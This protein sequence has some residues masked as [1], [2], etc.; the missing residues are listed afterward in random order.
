MNLS[1]FD[2]NCK[3]SKKIFEDKRLLKYII[4]V[5]DE[6]L[7]KNF[8]TKFEL[9]LTSATPV[10][11][12]K[13]TLCSPNTCGVNA[14]CLEEN[15]KASCKCL[16]GFPVGDPYVSCRQDCVTNSHCSLDKACIN[17][18]CVDPC[19]GACGTDA[20][21]RVPNHVPICTCPQGYTGSPY[22]RCYPITGM[23]YNTLIFYLIN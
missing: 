6:F 18:R 1:L 12:T 20:E 21:C 10:P 9:I 11:P 13:A 15:G 8:Y 7:K 23:H 17:E 14:Q 16:A 2:F 19:P 5:S 3:I 22:R 4:S